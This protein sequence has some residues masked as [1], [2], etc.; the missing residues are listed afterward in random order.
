MATILPPIRVTRPR[1]T[2]QSLVQ[3]I[4]KAYNHT[5]FSTPNTTTPPHA[6]LTTLRLATLSLHS[7]SS[8]SYLTNIPHRMP[9]SLIRDLTHIS[10]PPQPGIQLPTASLLLLPLP[11]IVRLPRM[12]STMLALRPSVRSF[13]HPLHHTKVSRYKPLTFFCACVARRLFHSRGEAVQ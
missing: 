5:S 3:L 2:E 6:P 12:M 4:E 10:H 7:A 11:L 13:H 9:D 8:P 1:R